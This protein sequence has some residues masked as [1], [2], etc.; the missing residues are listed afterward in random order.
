M[1]RLT[2]EISDELREKVHQRAVELG[3]SKVEEYVEWL[4]RGDTEV[5]VSQELEAELLKALESPAR[6]LTPAMWAQK[7]QRLIERLGQA[8]AG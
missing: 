2:I 5:P 6:E 7:R 1:L 4:I 8:K 3:Y